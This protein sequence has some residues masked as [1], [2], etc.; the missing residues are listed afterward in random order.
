MFDLIKKYDVEF[1]VKRIFTE[2]RKSLKVFP[3]DFEFSREV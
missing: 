3:P 1:K 2:L